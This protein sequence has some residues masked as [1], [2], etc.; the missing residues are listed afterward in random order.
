MEK[1]FCNGYVLT[2]GFRGML[3]QSEA[4]FRDEFGG[5]WCRECYTA[6]MSHGEK[7]FTIAK[8]DL[9]KLMECA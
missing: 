9:N 3:C 7:V 1:M 4:V 8:E 2:G 5:V 6:L